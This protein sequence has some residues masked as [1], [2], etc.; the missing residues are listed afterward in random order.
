LSEAAITHSPHAYVPKEHM[1][2]EN[3]QEQSGKWTPVE[4]MEVQANKLPGFLMIQDG[5]GRKRAAMLL[6]SYGGER[7][8]ENMRR[9]V[10]DMAE[11]Y[12]TTK[13]VARTRLMEPC[14]RL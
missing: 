10:A 14:G 6:E 2:Q 1:T 12:K 7:S 11:Y 4:I 8:V 9:L 3:R 13:T 5:P